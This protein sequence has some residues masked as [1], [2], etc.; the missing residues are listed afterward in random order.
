MAPVSRSATILARRLLSPTLGRFLLVGT[1]NTALSYVVFRLCLRA[2]PTGRHA[3]GVA[4]LIAYT[5][6]IAWSFLWNRHW[7]FRS[8][9]P[10]AGQAVRFLLLQVALLLASADLI[11]LA[12]DRLR[13][14]ATPSWLVVTVLIALANFLGARFLVFHATE[15]S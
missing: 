7:T 9:R 8:R 4:Q 2:W 6:G 13:Y 12:V 14:P 3:A 5:I 11:G 10:A 1:S 15:S